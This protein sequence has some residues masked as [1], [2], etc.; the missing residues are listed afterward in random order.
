MKRRTSLREQKKVETREALLAQARTLFLN[1]GFDATTI[2]EICDGARVSRRTFFRYF[3]NKQALVFPNHQDR[4]DRFRGLLE[5]RRNQESV[6]ATLRQATE[7][8]AIEY[9]LYR[10]SIVEIQ[11]LIESSPLL[12][13]REREIDRE[14]ERAIEEAFTAEAGGTKEARRRALVLAGATI[15]VLRATMRFWFESHREADLR[16]MGMDALDSLE[17]GFPLPPQPN[18]DSAQAS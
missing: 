7:L 11:T 16:G 5:G 4:L 15:G 12:L 18:R 3:P 2:D 13:A 6:F 1:Q 10:D 14:W 8:F 9:D 17:S